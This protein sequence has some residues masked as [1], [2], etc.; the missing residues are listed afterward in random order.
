VSFGNDNRLGEVL[1]VSLGGLAFRCIAGEEPSISSG[2]LNV[3]CNNGLCLESFPF[4]MIWNLKISDAPPFH[5][6]TTARTGVQF[7]DLA[8]NQMSSLRHFIQ[9]HTSAD[10]EA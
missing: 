5:Y 10:P 1:N 6:I 9:S 8:K 4:K 2:K 7:T 3:H